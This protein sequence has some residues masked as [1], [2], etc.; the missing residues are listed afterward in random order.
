MQTQAIRRYD[1]PNIVVLIV[2]LLLGLHEFGTV[3][4]GRSWML[5]GMAQRMSYALQLHKE[6]EC[7]P[8]CEERTPFSVVDRE[9][10]RRT[11]W[12]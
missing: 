11:M 4:G 8:T 5:G 1:A 2:Y 9:T 7:D 3:Q 6:I 10:R 12:S